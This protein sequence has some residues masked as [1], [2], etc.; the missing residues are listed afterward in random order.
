M[1]QQLQK[2]SQHVSQGQLLL[3]STSSQG[4]Q[5]PAA[6]RAASQGLPQHML[7]ALDKVVLKQ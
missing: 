5:G 1:L 2:L 6:E 4:L 3:S 7:Q